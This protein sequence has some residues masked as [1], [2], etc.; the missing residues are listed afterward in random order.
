MVRNYKASQK[1]N[2]EEKDIEQAIAEA[3]MGHS[4]N[5]TAKKYNVPYTT[6]RNR[7]VGANKSSKRGRKPIFTKEE[8]EDLVRII[9]DMAEWGVPIRDREIKQ[10]AKYYVLKNNVSNPLKNSTPGRDWLYLFMNRLV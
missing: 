9:N 10:I 6:L 1:K 2:Y 3:R 4:L 8:K 7:Y 5:Q